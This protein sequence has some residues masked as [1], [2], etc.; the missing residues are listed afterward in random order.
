MSWETLH[1]IF[2]LRAVFFRKPCLEVASDKGFAFPVGDWQ[3]FLLLSAAFLG[4]SVSLLVS[5]QTT[6]RRDPL[7]DDL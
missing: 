2:L 7:Y 6:M 3:A 5:C 1:L 4:E